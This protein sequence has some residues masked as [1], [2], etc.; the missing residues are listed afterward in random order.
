MASHA[1]PY[2]IKKHKLCISALPLCFRFSTTTVPGN[3]HQV[4]S[5]SFSFNPEFANFNEIPVRAH[6]SFT[7]AYFPASKIVHKSSRPSF[8]AP[9]EIGR[10]ALRRSTTGHDRR[11]GLHGAFSIDFDEKKAQSRPPVVVVQPVILESTGWT[12]RRN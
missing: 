4:R 5:W 8:T 1:P 6:V 2:P 7:A 12:C 11:Q 9:N 10:L 3:Q